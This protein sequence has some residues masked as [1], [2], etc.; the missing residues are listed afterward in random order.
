MLPNKVEN[1]IS[2]IKHPNEINWNFI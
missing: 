2:L 1:L